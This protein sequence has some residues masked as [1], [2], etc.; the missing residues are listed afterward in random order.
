MGGRTHTRTHAHA[1]TY[2]HTHIHTR[3]HTHARTYARARTPRTHVHTHAHAHTHANTHVHTLARAHTRA[4]THHTHARTH[5]K[6]FKKKL[7]SKQSGIYSNSSAVLLVLQ[8]L[9]QMFNVINDKSV[10]EMILTYLL[11]YSLHGAEPFFKANRFS[12]NQEIPR[13]L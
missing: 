11:T 8:M 7:I 4:N 9:K 1:H 6:D 2:T 3:A 10:R 13:I 12:A 5:I